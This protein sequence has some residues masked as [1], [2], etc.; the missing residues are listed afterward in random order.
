MLLSVRSGR[1]RLVAARSGHACAI[2]TGR[3]GRERLPP[4][5]PSPS[6]SPV[7]LIPPAGNL[8]RSGET[9]LQIPAPYRRD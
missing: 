8:F 2:G 9:L 7:V 5:G 4:A 3:D 1:E 6:P